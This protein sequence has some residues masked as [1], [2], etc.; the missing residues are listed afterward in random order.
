MDIR[1]ITCEWTLGMKFLSP[2][3][4]EKRE[5]DDDEDNDDDND[6]D[7]EEAN[8]NETHSMQRLDDTTLAEISRLDPRDVLIHQAGYD[9]ITDTSDHGFI[10]DDDDDGD[11]DVEEAN[12][13]ETHTMQ[14]LDDNE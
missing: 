7:V 9:D 2:N 11:A 6:D 4:R 5:K 14:R 12:A 3:L 13:N 8:T 1:D 10:S